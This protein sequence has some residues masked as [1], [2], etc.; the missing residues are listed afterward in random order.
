MNCSFNNL[1]TEFRLVP[2][3]FRL[4]PLD[5]RFSNIYIFSFQL[6][7]NKS[8]TFPTYCI[9]IDFGQNSTVFYVVPLQNQ[10]IINYQY[11]NK[12]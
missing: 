10:H 11:I 8:G 6:F 1:L 2:L 4:V 9:K 5:F 12:S 7:T 3:L